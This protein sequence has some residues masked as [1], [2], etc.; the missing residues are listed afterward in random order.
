MTTPLLPVGKIKRWGINYHGLVK[1]G[2]MTLPDNST[3]AYPQPSTGDCSLINF[4]GATPAVAWELSPS[5]HLLNYGLMCGGNWGRD[6]KI[7]EQTLPL[8]LYRDGNGSVWSV[9]LVKVSNTVGVQ[10]LKI[11]IQRWGFFRQ[12]STINAGTKDY[13]FD[14]DTGITSS[15]GLSIFLGFTVRSVS[16]KGNKVCFLAGYGFQSTIGEITLSGNVSGSTLEGLVIS[17]AVIVDHTQYVQWSQTVNESEVSIQGGSTRV[18]SVIG[19]NVDCATSVDSVSGPTTITCH[20]EFDT[21]VESNKNNV[22]TMEYVSTVYYDRLG[23]LKVLSTK[24]TVT[25]FAE[26]TPI[27]DESAGG[28]FSFYAPSWHAVEGAA[29]G[30]CSSNFGYTQDEGGTSTTTTTKSGVNLHSSI[31]LKVEL[32]LDGVAITTI[33]SETGSYFH[34]I[35]EIEWGVHV[36]WPTENGIVVTQTILI[37]EQSDALYTDDLDSAIDDN[38]RQYIEDV[39][40]NMLD[41]Y[42]NFVEQGNLTAGGHSGVLNGSD[43]QIKVT[44][45]SGSMYYLRY[46]ED[47]QSSSYSS[48]MPDVKH[49]EMATP[50]GSDGTV[51]IT[52]RVNRYG[53]FNPATEAIVRNSDELVCFV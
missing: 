47:L 22:T 37:D 48:G 53:S 4:D 34:S 42:E 41:E 33:N 43:Y 36:P 52:D 13:L 3:I 25:D 46:G 12:T 50:E 7:A 28:N 23:D 8:M 21:L 44:K 39:A 30:P 49:Y 31:S 40:Q 16:P 32:L 5:K 27:S 15:P 11:T 1:N 19:N 29:N 35:R 17:T 2:Q 6:N 26:Y 24:V 14:Y 45:V 9:N 18:D 51:V 38:S 20:F 10:H